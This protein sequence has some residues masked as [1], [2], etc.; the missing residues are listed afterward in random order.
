MAKCKSIVAATAVVA[1]VLFAHG[2]NV[3]SVT[4]QLGTLAGSSSPYTASS[5]AYKTASEAS[6]SCYRSAEGWYAGLMLN[7]ASKAQGASNTK[8]K[9]EDGGGPNA[10]DEYQVYKNLGNKTPSG[11][12][13]NNELQRSGLT[14]YMKTTEWYIYVTPEFMYS[15]G[16]ADYTATLTIG[17]NSYAITVPHDIVLSDGTHQWY[18]AV[19][20]LGDK[21]YGE[22]QHLADQ[23]SVE[24]YTTVTFLSE[25]VGVTFGEGFAASANGDGTWGVT[26]THSHAWSFAVSGDGATLTIPSALE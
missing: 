15:L 5:L 2:A 17:D 3:S 26:M 22:A 23:I 21:V 11:C 7:W 10:V 13:M 20:L 14:M 4:K 25:P 18:P 19:G 12:G 6:S 1:S 16:G 24:N 9:V 8:A